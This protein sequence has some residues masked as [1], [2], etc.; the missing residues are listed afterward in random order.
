MKHYIFS[1]LIDLVAHV[2]ALL[3]ALPGHPLDSSLKV[4]CAV[5]ADDLWVK[6]EHIFN[7]VV[8][9]VP[10]ISS[11]CVTDA[12]GTVVVQKDSVSTSEENTPSGLSYQVSE[13]AALITEQLTW[14]DIASVLKSTIPLLVPYLTLRISTLVT[15]LKLR[16]SAWFTL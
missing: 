5:R 15:Y 11:I 6:I 7:Q 1:R 4:V 13:F 10:Q 3:T 2:E 12:D 8:E 14:K 16:I 9:K